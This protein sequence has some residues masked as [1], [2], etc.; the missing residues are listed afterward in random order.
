MLLQHL[1]EYLRRAETK[2]IRALHRRSS[3]VSEG[4]D[5]RQQL[6]HNQTVASIPHFLAVSSDDERHGG[7]SGVGHVVHVQHLAR[8]HPIVPRRVGWLCLARLRQE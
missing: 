2:Y 5:G 8:R 3:V 4:V 6:D 7:E 1:H